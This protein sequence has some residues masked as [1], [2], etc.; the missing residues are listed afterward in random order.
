MNVQ[1]T[2]GKT[3]A[4]EWTKLWDEAEAAEVPLPIAYRVTTFDG[5]H[6]EFPLDTFG[7]KSFTDS[8]NFFKLYFSQAASKNSARA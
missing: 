2:A 4:Q 7:K 8:R 5:Q 6:V 3:S 1:V